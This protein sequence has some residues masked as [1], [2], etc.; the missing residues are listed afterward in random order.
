MAKTTLNFNAERE[1]GNNT[2]L[3]KN[4]NKVLQEEMVQAVIDTFEK[5]DIKGFRILFHVQGNIYSIFMN[6]DVALQRA[7]LERDNK[8]LKM[9]A[10][11]SRAQAI[12][13]AQSAYKLGTM[14]ELEAIQEK[15]NFH[16]KGIAVEYMLAHKMRKPFD[17]KKAWYKGEGEFG[18]YE[19]KYFDFGDKVCASSPRAKL[20]SRKQLE[21]LGYQF[22]A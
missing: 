17:H 11:F 18:G 6:T 16:N 8:S 15:G 19:V 4:S 13:L 3:G 5:K 10:P 7:K 1:K 12:E 20:T 2:G 22:S 21:K 14:E 9:F